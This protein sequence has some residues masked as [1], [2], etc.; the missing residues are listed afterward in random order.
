LGPFWWSAIKKGRKG[1]RGKRKGKGGEKEKGKGGKKGE[2]FRI[3][4]VGVI[5][6]ARTM[7]MVVLGASFGPLE[8]LLY[9]TLCIY[10]IEL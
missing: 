5:C 2:R 1:K 7:A 3:A 9:Q 10:I 4:K 8:G 6:L